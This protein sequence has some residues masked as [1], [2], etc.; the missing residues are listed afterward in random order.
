MKIKEIPVCGLG[1]VQARFKANPNSIKRL[2]FD[3]AT[4]RKIGAMCKALAAARKVYRCLEPVELQKV[5]GTLHHGGIVAIVEQQAL[6]TPTKDDVTKWIRTQA[7]LLILDRVGNAHNLGAIART[8][9]FFGVENIIIVDHPQQAVPGEAAHRVAEG[10]LESVEI[11]AVKDLAAFCRELSTHYRVVGTAVVGAIS[12]RKAAKGD[13]ASAA[14]PV[15]VVLG[16]EEHGLASD[17]AKA[18]TVLVTI[19]GS[20]RVESLNVSVAAAVLCW[21]FFA[22]SR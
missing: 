3:Y 22:K 8:A 7:P 15:A 18:C 2:F 12:L 10:G 14:K 16:N 4:G 13:S 11:F 6:R 17:V 20:G 5:A 1:A 21:E 19:P 9:A